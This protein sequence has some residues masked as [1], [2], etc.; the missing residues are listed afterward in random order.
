MNECLYCSGQLEEKRM[1]R[2]QE[3]EGKYFIIENLPAL[4]CKQ[5][6]EIYFTPEAHDL[7]IDLI[8]SGAEPIR[9]ER[10]IVLDASAA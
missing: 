8:T 3:Y 2:V 5:C 10:V 9:V 4:V 1:T 7:V 6:G